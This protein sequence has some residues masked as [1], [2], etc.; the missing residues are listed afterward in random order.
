MF[1]NKDNLWQKEDGLLQDN[2]F[3]D[4]FCSSE[5][6]T[7]SSTTIQPGSGHPEE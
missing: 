5:M 3:A 1:S 4:P 7:T 6:C 2:V